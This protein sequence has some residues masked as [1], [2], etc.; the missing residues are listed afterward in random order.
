MIGWAAVTLPRYHGY[1]HCCVRAA[2]MEE[3]QKLGRITIMAEKEQSKFPVT[4]I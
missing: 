4:C 2:H 1:Q 3:A